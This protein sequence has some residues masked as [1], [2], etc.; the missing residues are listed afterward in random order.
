[1]VLSD[2]LKLRPHHVVGDTQPD[3]PANNADAQD[4]AR[5]DEAESQMRRALGLLGDAPRHRPEPL[6][7]PSHRMAERFSGGQH[8]RRFVQ[9]GDV[10]VTVL[11]RDLGHEVPAQRVA[12]PVTTPTSNRLQRLEASLAAETAAREKAERLLAD[13]HAVVRDLQTKIGHAELART[14]AVETLRRE[15][16]TTAQLRHDLASWPARLSEANGR[17][18]VAEKALTELREQLQEE[19]RARRAAEKAVK[20]A[21][22][23]KANAEEL[24]HRHIP[25][26]AEQEWTPPLPLPVV[27]RLSESASLSPA[28]RR[29]R[30]AQPSVAEQEPVKWW[31]N[32]KHAKRR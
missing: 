24:T 2:H 12:N 27:K 13:A 22:A 11:R 17:Y 8:R 3:S 14:E 26:N 18:E 30:A 9:D 32:E 10:P 1:M 19:Q 6:P 20:A 25:A 23:D 21:E 5:I 7:E 29:R 28:I 31:L 16:D 15:R 4:A